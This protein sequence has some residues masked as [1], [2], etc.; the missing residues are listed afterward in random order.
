M[1]LSRLCIAVDDGLDLPRPGQ[2]WLRN[3]YRVHQR[4]CMAFPS[5]Q[6]KSDD[7]DF[8]KPFKPE[9]FGDKQVHV[10]RKETSGFLF[11]IDPIMRGGVAILVQSALRPDWDYAFHNA[12]YF[13]AAKPETKDFNPAFVQNQVLRFRLFANPTRKIDTKSGSDGKRRHGKRVPVPSDQLVNWLIVRAEAGGFAVDQNSI[14]IQP[15]YV[16]V[17]KEGK[18]Q[19]KRLRSVRYDGSLEVT[20]PER[21]H[22]TIIKGIGPAKAFG[23][24]LL[25]VAPL[26]G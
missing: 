12:G 4:L 19:G 1:F 20:D 21:L 22:E 24:G 23:F 16:Y 17:N 9:D 6:R 13:L 7:P 15:G 14:V 26:P 18:R 2:K 3:L 11:R 8:L 10:E 25:S 5:E